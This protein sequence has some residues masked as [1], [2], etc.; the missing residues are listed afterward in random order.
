MKCKLFKM[1][2]QQQKASNFLHVFI[3]VTRKTLQNQWLPTTA[4]LQLAKHSQLCKNCSEEHF[5]RQNATH[6]NS[7]THKSLV[8][9]TLKLVHYKSTRGHEKIRLSHQGKHLECLK[10]GE[11][12][13]NIETTVR[14]LGESVLEQ[15][16]SL[17]V[18]LR[19]R[20]KNRLH[21]PKKHITTKSI[22]VTHKRSGRQPP[23]WPTTFD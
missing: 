13:R 7:P 19:E 17:Y 8:N 18:W 16:S 14:A 11:G 23:K 4:K 6:C 1:T 9:N 21:K 15:R 20:K 2:C 3:D 5:E 12:E 10:N 22:I